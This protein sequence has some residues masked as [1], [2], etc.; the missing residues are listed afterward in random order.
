VTRSRIATNEARLVVAVLR[1]DLPQRVERLALR[2]Q[3]CRDEAVLLDEVLGALRVEHDAHARDPAT[4]LVRL[5]GHLPDRDPD[6]G[7]L[8]GVGGDRGADRRL[9]VLGVLQTGR[10]DRRLALRALERRLRV[11]ELGLRCGQS[12]LDGLQVEDGLCE[13]GVDVLERRRELVVGLLVRGRLLLGG[14]AAIRQRVAQG[15]AGRRRER[16]QDRDQDGREQSGEAVA[17]AHVTPS[18]SG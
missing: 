15:G 5:A 4:T 10:D 9:L 12:L 16:G 1:L 7:A 13:V 3:R 11:E 2:A 8:A 18:C 17:S 6:L 14:L